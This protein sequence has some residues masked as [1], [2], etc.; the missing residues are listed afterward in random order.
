MRKIDGTTTKRLKLFGEKFSALIKQSIWGVQMF[1]R[2]DLE[3]ILISNF[4][5]SCHINWDY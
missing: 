3:R 5:E 4:I 2:G 1:S